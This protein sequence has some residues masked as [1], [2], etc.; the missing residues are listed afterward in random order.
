MDDFLRPLL[1]MVALLA[2]WGFILAGGN[3]LI[4]LFFHVWERIA[5]RGLPTRK[6]LRRQDEED[7]ENGESRQSVDASSR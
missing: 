5:E 4:R 3:F 2:L 6:A 1:M 7:A